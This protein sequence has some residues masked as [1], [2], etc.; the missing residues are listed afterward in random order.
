V[1]ERVANITLIVV[2]VGPT[3]TDWR[4]GS[5]VPI[6]FDEQRLADLAADHYL[7]DVEASTPLGV[8]IVVNQGENEWA[9]A[10]DDEW[11]E[12]TLARDWIRQHMPDEPSSSF[13]PCQITDA[14]KALAEQ[15]KVQDRTVGEI[16]RRGHW[17]SRTEALRQ[18]HDDLRGVVEQQLGMASVRKEELLARLERAERHLEVADELVSRTEYNG[19]GPSLNAAQS[20]IE[21]TEDAFA[22]VDK[23]ESSA[24]RL[25]T[26]LQELRRQI[27]ARR[28]WWRPA[29]EQ[30]ETRLATCQ[31]RLRVFETAIGGSTETAQVE[32]VK[33]RAT[34]CMDDLEEYLE[35]TGDDVRTTS[36][37]FWMFVTA[38]FFLLALVVISMRRTKAS[39]R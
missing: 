29:N 18:R 8:A 2:D 16:V 24:E 22:D 17:T 10:L 1:D 34:A 25:S 30:V 13:V 28:A 36:I 12:A 38:I 14:I 20:L 23:L 19:A 26:R 33:K 31:K 35:S 11:E 5:E 39:T 6:T 3:K 37:Y 21:D 27:E 4:D 32:A 15:A 7:L 9:F